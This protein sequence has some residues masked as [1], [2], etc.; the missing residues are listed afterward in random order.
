MRRE[1]NRGER[2]LQKLKEVELKG[3]EG[4]AGARI[5]KAGLRVWRRECLGAIGPVL[6]EA[7]RRGGMYLDA[8]ESCGSAISSSELLGNGDEEGSFGVII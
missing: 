1:M 8:K 5:H 6:T 4:S 2:D 3:L 7:I